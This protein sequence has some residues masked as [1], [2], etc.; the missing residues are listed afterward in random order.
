[1]KFLLVLLTSLLVARAYADK[2][3]GV[4]LALEKNI[5][6]VILHS[7]KVDSTRI[8][9]G[10]LS[11][12]VNASLPKTF[13][14]VENFEDKCNNEFKGKRK[15]LDKNKDCKY[16]NHNLIESVIVKKTNYT[17]PKEPNEIER[18]IVTRYIYNRGSFQQND[19][20]IVLKYKNDKKQ[21]VMHIKQTMLSDEESKQYL[22]K[23]VKKDS[24]FKE[25]RGNF[26]MTKLDENKTQFDYEY[27]GKSDHWM[28]NKEM[29]VNEVYEGIAKGI[30]F[31]WESIEKDVAIK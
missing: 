28:L 4:E 2:V 17:G 5:N 14:A 18:Y 13:T 20:M 26:I 30:N 12:V 8:Y 22:D 21:D 9:H 31:L 29:M 27:I 11:K 19:L 6:G 15:V 7:G 25:A 10:Q 16:H 3:D 1:M 23:P 24:A